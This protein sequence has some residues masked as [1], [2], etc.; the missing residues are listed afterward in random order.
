MVDQHLVDQ[1]TKHDLV[2][3]MLQASARDII[4]RVFDLVYWELYA[5]CYSSDEVY[6]WL[7]G[8][9]PLPATLAHRRFLPLDHRSTVASFWNT[10]CAHDYGLP[11]PRCI[12]GQAISDLAPQLLQR[13]T[14]LPFAHA[15]NTWYA[16]CEAYLQVCNVDWYVSEAQRHR[17]L[18]LWQPGQERDTPRYIAGMM[19]YTYF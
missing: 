2:T 8:G 19:A 10:L 4:T 3:L 13:L 14:Q 11:Q 5:N 18:T 6:A 1:T 7:T 9:Q 12:D 17:Q 15:I 16:A